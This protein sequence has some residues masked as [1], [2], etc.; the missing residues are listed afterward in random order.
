M[1]TREEKKRTDKFAAVREIWD[2]LISNCTAHYSPGEHITINEQLLGFSGRCPFRIYIV[3]KPAKY[4]IKLIMVCDAKT[5]YMLNTLPYLGKYTQPP[6]GMAL[7]HYVT[8][9]LVV[10]YA[11]SK[12]IITGDNWFGSVPLVNDLLDNYNL[13][14]VGTVQANKAQIT[15][16]MIDKKRFTNGQSAF[17]FD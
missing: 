13:T 5:S 10:L 3:N 9:K 15:P 16:E 4:G 11:N 17:L 1:E 2:K 14:Y 12:R 7:G 8:T 6:H